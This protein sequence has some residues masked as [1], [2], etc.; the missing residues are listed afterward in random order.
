MTID[1]WGVPHISAS[2]TGDLFQAQGFNA[3]RDRLFQMDTWRR[4]GLGELSEVLGKN[5]MEQDRASRLFLY[6]GD[7]EKEWASYGP[8]AKEVATRFAAGVNAY[9]DWL[10]KNPASVPE[11]FRKLGYKPAR[12]K[13]QDLVRIRTHGLVSNITKEVTRAKLMCLG[14]PEASKYLSKLEPKHKPEVPDG[15]D[16]CSL[17]D[18]VLDTYDLATATVS[19]SNGTMQREPKG[20]QALR[21]SKGGSNAWVVSPARTSTGRPILA[22][23]PHRL[24]YLLPGN[25]YITHLSAPGLNIIGAGEPWNPGISMGHNGSASFALTNLAADQSDLYV[26]DLKPDDPSKYRHLGG[27]AP[28]KTVEENI[29]VAGQGH[30]NSLLTF[31]HHGPVIKVD[32]AKNK[33]YAIRT[34][35]TQPGTSAYLGSLNFQKAKSFTEFSAAMRKWK[36]PGSNFLYADKKGDVGWVPGALSPNREGKGYDG[37]LPVPGDGRYEWTGFSNSSDFPSALNPKA[38]FFATANEYNFPAGYNPPGLEWAERYRKDRIDNVLSNASKVSIKGTTDL[39]ND[40]KSLVATEI[41][42]YLSDL[43]SSDPTTKKAL[44]LLRGYDGIASKDSAET[45]L[46]ETWITNVLYPA[47]A[48]TMLPKP[49]AEYLTRGG[50]IEDFRVVTE[51]FADPKEWF[52]TGG[53]QARDKLL[54]DTLPKAYDQVSGFLGTDPGKWRWDAA[55]IQYFQHPLGGPNVGPIPVD[56]TSHTVRMSMYLPSVS[57]RIQVVGPTFKMALDVGSWDNSLAINAPGQ[58]GDERSPH[59]DDLAQKWGAGEYFPLLY[60]ESAITENA[61]SKLTLNPA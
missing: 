40:V 12:W 38:E 32:K 44:D 11:E 59:Y 54:L 41:L 57:P 60:S 19:F 16:L 29:P 5:Y 31:T 17:P 4:K 56:G 21:E 25:R 55:Q 24:N 20:L 42:P 51:S 26:Y 47:W 30:Q 28:M 48:E 61:E 1:K 52:G 22:A 58:S 53:A 50:I 45:V 33:A 9:V 10:D 37:L 7:M 46:F 3:A 15:L 35:W 14:G 27:W 2:N 36:T 43:K 23:D 6:R 34:V 18:D 13:P 39:Q 8:Q 49:A